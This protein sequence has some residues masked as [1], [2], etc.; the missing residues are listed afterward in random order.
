MFAFV[1]LSTVGFGTPHARP[2]LPA[3]R[4]VLSATPPTSPPDFQLCLLDGNVL[5]CYSLLASIGGLFTSGEIFA[6]A[7]LDKDLLDI[8]LAF[9]AASSL[10]VSWLLSAL[11]CGACRQDWFFLEGEEHAQAPLGVSRLFATWLVCGPLLLLVRA[12]SSTAIPPA[13][14]KTEA[15]G[16]SPLLSDAASADYF[17]VLVVMTLWRRW[18]LQRKGMDI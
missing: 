11:L 8:G 17:A 4:V 15:S 2:H 18:L 13:L 14:F 12:A 7:E 1:A 10:I 16:I 9:S 5:L 3:H 6:T